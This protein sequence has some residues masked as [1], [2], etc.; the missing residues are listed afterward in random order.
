MI[1]QE[2]RG[3]DHSTSSGMESTSQKTDSFHIP[4]VDVDTALAKE[5]TKLSCHDRNKAQE[6]LHG[7]QSAMPE[8]TPELLQTSLQQ[9]EAQVQLIPSKKAY[10]HAVQRLDASYIQSD[11]FR[12]SFVRAAM[13]DISRAAVRYIKYLELLHEF[14]GDFGLQRRLRFTD[15]NKAEKDCLKEGRRQILPSRDRSGRLIMFEKGS[16]ATDNRNTRVCDT[17]MIPMVWRI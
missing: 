1:D 2:K 7:V 13:Y 8:E 9:F 14:F 3:S 17:W 4:D 16:K 10:D 15:L 5:I 11:A 12:L 6:E